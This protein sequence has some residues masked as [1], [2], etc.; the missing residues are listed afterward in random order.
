MY[1]VNNPNIPLTLY[2]KRLPEKLKKCCTENSG[3]NKIIYKILNKV[4]VFSWRLWYNLFL[5]LCMASWFLVWRT[6][7]Q[8]LLLVKKIFFHQPGDARE[9]YYIS[10]QELFGPFWKFK[11]HILYFCARIVER[12]RN[13]WKEVH[14][15]IFFVVGIPANGSNVAFNVVLWISFLSIKFS[16]QRSTFS[17]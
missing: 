17:G 7:F 15:A 13:H 3:A 9:S 14:E 2:L 4:P 5:V 8:D 10:I 16:S 12:I 11:L 1:R 6:F